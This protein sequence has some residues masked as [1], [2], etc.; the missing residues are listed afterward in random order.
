MAM[1]S[2][3]SQKVVEGA[4]VSTYTMRMHTPT[5]AA[6]PY[7]GLYSFISPIW[8]ST[9]DLSP[10]WD[11]VASYAG[12][13]LQYALDF[14]RAIVDVSGE[15]HPTVAVLSDHSRPNARGARKVT[16]ERRRLHPLYLE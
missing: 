1:Y 8:V 16:L 6:A 10:G 14:V 2:L 3:A 9:L 7:A 5:I 13:Q 4:R 11:A 15:T 12:Q